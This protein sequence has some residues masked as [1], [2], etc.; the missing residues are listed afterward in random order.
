MS[1]DNAYATAAL[2]IKIDLPDKTIRAIEGGV[3][4][5]TEEDGLTY[6]Y[7][8]EDP[9]YGTVAAGEGVS[10]GQ[11]DEIPASTLS[12]LPSSNAAAETLTSP[13]MQWSPVDIKI[14]S[15]D[16]ASGAVLEV[17]DYFSGVIDIPT[18]RE[19]SQG[20]VIDM[21]LVSNSELFFQQNDGNR[22]SA[23]NHTRVHPGERGLDNMTGI[24]IDVPWM[25]ESRPRNQGSGG[26]SSGFTTG[27]SF[28]GDLNSITRHLF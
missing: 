17:E 20:R 22:L 6:A 11:G 16:E 12:F 19:T 18:F 24:E 9:D 27:G 8:S 5:V 23:E 13:D 10:E 1:L 7:T 3:A 21:Q 26:S 28:G 4:I 2:I 15:M 25:T 14:V